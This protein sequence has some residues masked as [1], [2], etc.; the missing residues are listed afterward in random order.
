MLVV[1]QAGAKEIGKNGVGGGG[2][3]EGPG[4]SGGVITAQGGGPTGRL[5]ADLRDN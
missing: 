3:P 5:P 4:D 1:I 2:L